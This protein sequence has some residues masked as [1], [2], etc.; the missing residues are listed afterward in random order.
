MTVTGTSSLRPIC[1]F[2]RWSCCE[3]HRAAALVHPNA[4]L[5]L[6][7]V[8]GFQSQEVFP[9]AQAVIV[10]QHAYDQVERVSMQHILFKKTH[11]KPLINRAVN[12]RIKIFCHRWS[13]SQTA[14]LH[15]KGLVDA[16]TLVQRG[17]FDSILRHSQNHFLI[18]RNKR[19]FS[20]LLLK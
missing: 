4:A 1:P 13:R 3:T 8:S 15:I 9:R 5:L 20:I 19:K 2:R 17:H 10:A 11:P 16:Y 6:F 18:S 7:G 12:S 14:S